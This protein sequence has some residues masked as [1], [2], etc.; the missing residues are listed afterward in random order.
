MKKEVI[1]AKIIK[2]VFIIITVIFTI[3]ALIIFIK[4]WIPLYEA[5]FEKS[6]EYI[7]KLIFIGGIACLSGYIADYINKSIKRDISKEEKKKK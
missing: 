4:M 5:N 7:T 6:A 3:P 2:W 1:I